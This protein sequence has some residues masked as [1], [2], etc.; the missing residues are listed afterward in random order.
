MKT[1]LQ[2]QWLRNWFVGGPE[3]V[4]YSNRG[5]IVH[6]SQEVFAD[7]LRQVWCNAASV[8]TEDAK[9]II[10]FGGIPSKRIEPL[11][12]IKSSLNDSG[13]RIT[14]VREAGSATEGKRQA[15]T[16]LRIKSKPKTEFDIWAVKE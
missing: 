2:D 12:I 10:R 6:S 15:E 4:D 9:M 5:Q 7:D 3:T 8:C 1:Y 11:D 13:W 16:F 14:A